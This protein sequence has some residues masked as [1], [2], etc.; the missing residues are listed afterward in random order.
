M[1]PDPVERMEAAA[2][3]AFDRL[4]VSGTSIK[5]P[6]CGEPLDFEAEG[7]T[8]SPNPYAMPV[9]GKCLAS[10]LDNTGYEPRDCGEKI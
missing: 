8:M 2:E 3:A 9:C 10:F 1:I 4:H 7:G 5:C 6:D